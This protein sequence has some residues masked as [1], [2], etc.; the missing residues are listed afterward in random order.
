MA[1]AAG[2]LPSNRSQGV[3]KFVLVSSIGC[4]D[5]LFP[6]N[7]FWGVLLWKK[8]GE[9]AVQRSG[10]DYTI[11]RPGERAACTVCVLLSAGEGCGAWC[12]RG[13]MGWGAGLGGRAGRSACGVPAGRAAVPHALL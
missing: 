12:L 2:P 10:L 9:L 5:P 11:V 4:D 13:R 6:L 7:L 1:L 3:K 8:Q